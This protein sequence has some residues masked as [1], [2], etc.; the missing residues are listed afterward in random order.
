MFTLAQAG[1][2]LNRTE[3]TTWYH[4]TTHLKPVQ[5]GTRKFLTEEQI[6]KI[7]R[8]HIK[9]RHD[10]TL[11]AIVDRMTE[12]KK[13]KGKQ[14]AEAEIEEKLMPEFKHAT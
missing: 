7:A 12:F 11:A 10:E 6:M 4:A 9:L 14:A 1:K 5:I 3:Y 8:D 13:K 2:I